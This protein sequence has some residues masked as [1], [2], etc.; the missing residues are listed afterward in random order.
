MTH[1]EA[2]SAQ[3]ETH[4]ALW[5]QCF[6]EREELFL[7]C[8]ELVEGNGEALTESN[9]VHISSSALDRQTGF[10]GKGI[11]FAKCKEYS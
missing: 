8:P 7:A 9:N 1:I 4:F 5:G 3:L 6:T 2:Y 10:V 11:G